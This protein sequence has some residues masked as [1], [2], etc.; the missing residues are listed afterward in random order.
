MGC[1]CGKSNKNFKAIINKNKNKNN[2]PV[3][4]T[5]NTPNIKSNP[6][7][8]VPITPITP[9]TPMTRAEKIRLRSLRVQARNE[10]MARRNQA[11]LASQKAKEDQKK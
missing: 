5:P 9:I 3:L 6:V 8:T 10:R 1:N 11:I 4:L 2:I 7:Q